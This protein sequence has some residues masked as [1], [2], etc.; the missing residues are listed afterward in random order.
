MSVEFLTSIDVEKALRRLMDEYDEFH[1]A[2][3]WGTDNPLSDQLLSRSAKFKAVTFGLA[4]A[5]TDP[6]LVKALVGV[7]GSYVVTKFP[8]GTY[9][10]KVFAFRSKG[11]AAAIVGSANFTRG[12]L[13]SNHEA[14]VL[15]TGT[16]DD[17][18]LADVLAFTATSARLGM[19]VTAELAERYRLS[20]ELA[21]MKPRQP[22]DPLDEIPQDSVK[23]LSSPLVSM[24]WKEY[25]RSV[26]GS[27]QHHVGNSLG[28]LRT[29]QAWLAA[30]PSFGDLSTPQ[31]KA[32]AGV[33]GEADKALS[34]EL[35]QD[36]G[37]VRLNARSRGL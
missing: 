37:M 15:I 27:Q 32:L 26:R 12:G 2:V 35:G 31:R 17:G 6:K 8:G 18:A 28:L 11:R 25:A 9:H 7:A 22:R 10:P 3:A 19:A 20:H 5:Q 4:F 29:A 30:V 21:A 16:A 24:S 1:W 14:S 13:S 36:W 23:G 33:I 34:D